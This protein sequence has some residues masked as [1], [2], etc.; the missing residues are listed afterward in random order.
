VTF[1]STDP[2]LADFASPR[3]DFSVLSNYSS[4][5]AGPSPYLTTFASLLTGKRVYAGGS[6]TGLPGS[7]WILATFSDPESAIRVFP[8]ID[9][10]ESAFDGYQYRIEGSNDLNTWTA[11]YDTLTVIATPFPLAIF[12]IGG[13]TGTAPTAVNAILTPGAGPGGAVGYIADFHFGTAYKYYAFGASS[14]AVGAGNPDQELS[15]VS[16]IGGVP[17]PA[18]WAMVLIAFGGLGAMKRRR[19]RTLVPLMS[20]RD[21]GDRLLRP[22][23]LRLCC[24]GG[25]ADNVKSR[26]ARKPWGGQ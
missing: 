8:N 5:D 18:T 12:T 16:A 26:R 11:L 15:G 23:P 13:F 2:T 6:L 4:G 3:T 22:R 14:L 10:L 20:A 1:Y 24:P 7:N 25:R 9:H 21:G 17:E 19:K